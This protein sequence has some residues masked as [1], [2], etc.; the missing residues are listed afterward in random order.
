MATEDTTECSA[1][2]TFTMT[3]DT[4]DMKYTITPNDNVKY[5]IKSGVL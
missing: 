2:F 3:A 4:T 1:K 5:F